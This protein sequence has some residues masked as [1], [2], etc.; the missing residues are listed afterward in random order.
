[1]KNEIALSEEQATEIV[2]KKR[3]G[4]PQ[5]NWGQEYVK[6]GDNARYLKHA[7]ATYNLPPIDIADP[8]KVDERIVWY[9]NHCINNDMKPAVQGL[10]NAIGISRDTL[11]AWCN[12]DTRALTHSDM[13]KKAHDLLKEL[14]E[15]YML[16]GKVNPVAGIFIGLNHFGYQNRTELV[17]TPNKPLGD[18]KTPEEIM[19][20]L[21]ED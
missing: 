10:C 16:N 15:E 7:L 9:F 2:K 14:Y 21:P 19:K 20:S 12:E 6:P 4:T 8:E 11:N 5:P 3:Q 18:N 17:I 13:A 1:M